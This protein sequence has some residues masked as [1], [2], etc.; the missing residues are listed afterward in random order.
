MAHPG[1]YRESTAKSFGFFIRTGPSALNCKG[2]VFFSPPGP[3]AINPKHQN[4]DTAW[5]SSVFNEK[6]VLKVP[7]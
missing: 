3:P 4:D 6:V 5:W 1:L 7:K 2:F